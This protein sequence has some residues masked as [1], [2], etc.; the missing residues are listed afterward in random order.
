MIFRPSSSV[1]ARSS[2]FTLIELAIGIAILALL[3]GSVLV[4]LNTQVESRKI[5]ETQRMLAQ[6]RDM[7]MGYVAAN[8]YF[9]CPADESSKGQEALGA[10]GHDSLTGACA[11]SVGATSGY[12]GYLPAATLGFAPVDPQGYGLDAWGSQGNRIRYAVY[13]DAG[14]VANA[15]IRS[16]GMAALGIPA[17]GSATLFNVCASGT[18]TGGS[19]CGSPLPP[20]QVVLT[21]NA[22]IVIWSVGA[23]SA[24]G[25]PHEAENADNDRVF[26][27]RP[28]SEVAGLQF[29]D[30]IAWVPMNLVISRMIAAG[31]LP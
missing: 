27:S 15:L 7:L 1:E 4:P 8:G 24:P 31:Q 2:G 10:T 22:A 17:L 11:A 9:P 20:G 25:S 29:D 6:A 18:G 28:R 30:L 5:D 23:S 19:D 26:V 3:I 16:G 12:H 13:S 14:T 21:T